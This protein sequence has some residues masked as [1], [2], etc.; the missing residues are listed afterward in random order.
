MPF[1][2]GGGSCTMLL[3]HAIS[4]FALLHLTVGMGSSSLMLLAV[5]IHSLLVLLISTRASC[6]RLLPIGIRKLT[7]T[8]AGSVASPNM[9]DQLLLPV[10]YAVHIGLFALAVYRMHVPVVLVLY[11]LPFAV[12]AVLNA[13]YSPQVQHLTSTAQ[14]I[15]SGAVLVP[16]LLCAA[17]VYSTGFVCELTVLWD[18]A[19]CLHALA[20][21]AVTIAYH[22]RLFAVLAS[23]V[24]AP[25]ADDAIGAATP[26]S[27]LTRMHGA[28]F[29]IS[30]IS[31]GFI[32]L[33][34]GDSDRAV[35]SNCGVLG[36][37]LSVVGCL[38]FGSN[39]PT[40]CSDHL[41]QSSIGEWLWWHQ[42]TLQPV[43]TEQNPPVTTELIVIAIA[44]VMSVAL[45]L[46]IQ[47]ITFIACSS[48][49]IT[50]VSADGASVPFTVITSNRS[51]GAGP[52]HPTHMLLTQML[53][54]YAVTR[55]H[56]VAAVSLTTSGLVVCLIIAL[57][58]ARRWWYDSRPNSF[59]S[60]DAMDWMTFES[61][62]Q[63]A[64]YSGLPTVD[65][66][67]PTSGYPSQS[68]TRS[69]A[70]LIRISVLVIAICELF[71][72]SPYGW[73][74]PNYSP[75]Q[76][77]SLPH[78]EP[79][80]A[81]RIE[82]LW[83]A[84]TEPGAARTPVP[85]VLHLTLTASTADS[86]WT[87][88]HYLCLQSALRNGI[89]HVFLHYIPGRAVV[90][91]GEWWD[92]TADSV[93]LVPVSDVSRIWG[94]P[95]LQPAHKSDLIRLHALRMYGG[96][97]LDT[98]VL[99]LTSLAPIL[100]NATAPH[101]TA[102]GQPTVSAELVMGGESGKDL[103]LYGYANG[104][105]SARPNA[106]FLQVWYRHL[107]TAFALD[108]WNCHS[109]VFPFEFTEK[110]KAQ[111]LLPSAP[112]ADS[113]ERWITVMHPHTFYRF[114]PSQAG[115][116]LLFATTP[117]PS[118]VSPHV[119]PIVG[120]HWWASLVLSQPQWAWIDPLHLTPEKLHLNTTFM[121]AVSSAYYSDSSLLP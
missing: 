86:A 121:A 70:S 89:S 23:P 108:C 11:L 49:A 119:T 55:Y 80:V 101:Y 56:L 54:A 7:S 110:I 76:T 41:M 44:H 120:L 6:K 67:L 66:S 93:T 58:F 47:Q 40:G 109:V 75:L 63:S 31:F 32:G 79:A 74:T 98:D 100:L 103:I 92:R 43:R 38:V 33:T 116:R 34:S 60:A 112:S 50:S 82:S 97:Y 73:L 99:T 115:L 61:T 104:V 105:M 94:R 29:A 27:I 84:A 1:V 10:L 88:V 39:S 53:V 77:L 64:A 83:E 51:G 9:S 59:A 36:V 91:S 17:F 72:S 14:R 46:V 28:C 62:A 2:G 13:W 16:L 24:P 52:V 15:R 87:F 78:P 30:I 19:T 114:P 25:A 5:P 69:A 68:N 85:P 26:Y 113:I 90:P 45:L 37:P 57:L 20:Y 12:I 95:V 96:V 107:R 102:P 8:P 118:L 3:V 42:L 71:A 106:R 81:A 35:A 4:A 21:T 111:R 117:P 48:G 65:P 22:Y 18:V